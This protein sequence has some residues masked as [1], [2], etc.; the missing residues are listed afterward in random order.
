[1]KVK[2][3]WKATYSEVVDLIPEEDETLERALQYL[4]ERA[5]DDIPPYPRADTVVKLEKVESE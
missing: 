5:E 4:K 3:T 2:I 1:M